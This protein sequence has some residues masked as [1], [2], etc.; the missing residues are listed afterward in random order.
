M[1]DQIGVVRGGFAGS[2]HKIE[3]WA[4]ENY[5]GTKLQESEYIKLAEKS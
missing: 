2:D 4:K 5:E 3:I 1:L